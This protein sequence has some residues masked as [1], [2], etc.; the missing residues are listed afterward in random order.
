[1]RTRHLCSPWASIGNQPVQVA[2][3][4][5]SS[6]PSRDLCLGVDCTGKPCL[7]VVLWAPPLSSR[8][9]CFT[10]S[11]MFRSLGKADLVLPE[12]LARLWAGLPSPASA[13][14]WHCG[15]CGNH[16]SKLCRT[17]KIFVF[18]HLPGL[19]QGFEVV[20]MWFVTVGKLPILGM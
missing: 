11:G 1:M 16:L 3:V 7:W 15:L 2:P 10:L 5:R 17:W 14:G 19:S 9:L 20:R 18:T 6:F 13:G 8:L 4:I 12:L